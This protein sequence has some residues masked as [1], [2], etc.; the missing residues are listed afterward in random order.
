[1]VF[2]HRLDVVRFL[3]RLHIDFKSPCKRINQS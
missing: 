2:D 3:Q 1:M